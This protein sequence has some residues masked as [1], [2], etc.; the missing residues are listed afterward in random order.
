MPTAAGPFTHAHRLAIRALWVALGLLTLAVSAV[1]SPGQTT[2]AQ[3]Q[4]QGLQGLWIVHPSADNPSAQEL[5]VFTSDGFIF[6]SQSPTSSVDPNATPAGVTQ[7]FNSQ[8]YGVWQP[9][10]SGANDFKF[11]TVA[12]NQNGDYVGLTSIHGSLTVSQ[13][14]EVFTG[15]YD[16][17]ILLP[18]GPAM[19]VVTGARVVGTRVTVGSTP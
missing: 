15:T 7:L 1:A 5:A 16:V 17:T 4:G 18:T 12:Y 13:T 8:G 3:Q 10:G 14:G 19:N 9:S 11:L 6:S 2:L